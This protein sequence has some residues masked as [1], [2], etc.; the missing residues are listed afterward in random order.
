MNRF[1]GIDGDVST[2]LAPWLLRDLG[3]PLDIA[4]FRLERQ[5]RMRSDIAGGVIVIQPTRISDLASI[6]R[7]AWSIMPPSDPRIA[8]GAWFH[9]EIYRKRGDVTLE[10]GRRVRLSRKQCDQIL[11]FEAMPDLHAEGWRQHAV[12]QALRRFGD[13]WEGNS[14]FE[15]FT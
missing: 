6:P 8:L 12:Y 9:D 7:P 11:C 5:L 2:Q 14:F 3:L 10:C 15:R 4:R 1:F 13:Q